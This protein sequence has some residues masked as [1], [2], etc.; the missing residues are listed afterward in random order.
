MINT[1]GTLDLEV[2]RLVVKIG[3]STLTT[4]DGR[5]DAA[6]LEDMAKQI[7]VLHKLGTQ[8]LIVSSAAI[9][10]GLQCLD[11]PPNRPDDIPTL[12]AAA[13]VGQIQLTQSYAKAFAKEEI[14]LGQVLITRN[15]T[16][17]REAYLHA[18]DTLER[19]LELG[20][21]PLVNENDT[22]AIDEIRFGDNDTLAAQVA[23]LVKAD[24]VVLLSDIEGLYTADPR[25]GEDAELLEH[26]GEFTHEIVEAAGSAGSERG[27]GGMF[28]KLEAARMLM[29]AS[30]PMVICEGHSENA[31]LNAAQGTLK[32]THFRRE[33]PAQHTNARRLWITLSGTVCGSVTV[34]KGAATALRERGS[35]LLPVGVVSCEGEFEKGSIVDIRDDE[36]LL[37]GRGI[38]KYSSDSLEEAAGQRSSTILQSA[39]FEDNTKTE[40]VHRDEMVIF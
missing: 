25:L 23:I 8:V 27:S 7:A 19:L 12:Q 31:I 9:V 17:N 32:G 35:S 37:I 21:I 22:I 38:S 13:A 11:M 5:L 39:D 16:V 1:E 20:V 28:T 33:T 3:S 34:D 40:V 6:Y 18:R 4:D 2:K 14:K 30:I 26:V 15:D 24:L 36:G 10:A 29:A